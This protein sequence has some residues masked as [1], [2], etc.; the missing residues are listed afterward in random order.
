MVVSL[1]FAVCLS[2]NGVCAYESVSHKLFHTVLYW[3]VLNCSTGPPETMREHVVAASNAMK[4]GNWKKCRDYIISVKVGQGSLL[5][6][7]VLRQGGTGVI[8]ECACSP[9]RWDRVHY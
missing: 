2:S 4:E 7:L 3:I 9:S 5:S 1:L 6:V 8:I